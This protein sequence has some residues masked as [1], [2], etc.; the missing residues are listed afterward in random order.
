MVKLIC[1]K[2]ELKAATFL[3]W[4]DASIGRLCKMTALKMIFPEDGQNNMPV[5]ASAAS[6]VLVNLTNQTNAETCT[7]DQDGVTIKGESVGDWKITISKKKKKLT[8]FI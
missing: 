7:L 1:T 4:D 6:L 8:C 2:K 3:E 5:I